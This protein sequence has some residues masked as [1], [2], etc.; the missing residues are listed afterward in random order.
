MPPTTIVVDLNGSEKIVHHM[1]KKK[2]LVLIKFSIKIDYNIL[3][4]GL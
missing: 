4:A 1:K 3:G 2:V